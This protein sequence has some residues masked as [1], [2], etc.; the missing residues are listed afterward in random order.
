M[1]RAGGGGLGCLGTVLVTLGGGVLLAV[2]IVAVFFFFAF[3]RPFHAAEGKL[4]A[5]ADR[6]RVAGTSLVHESYR[7]GY[8]LDNCP[9]LLRCYRIRSV[10]P[11][12]ALHRASVRLRRA[13]YGGGVGTGLLPTSGHSGHF[14]ATFFAQPR[15]RSGSCGTRTGTGA[16]ELSL[17]YRP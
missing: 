13:G 5:E 8:C 6:L 16:L 3:Y 10:P 9:A 11:G 2:A 1:K 4:Q 17:A 15:S 12:T 14:D 7:G